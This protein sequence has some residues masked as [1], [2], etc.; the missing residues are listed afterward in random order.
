MARPSPQ[1][2]S[3]S[4]LRPAGAA[5]APPDEAQ[6]LEQWVQLLAGRGRQ[7]G[8]DAR[9]DCRAPGKREAKMPEAWSRVTQASGRQKSGFPQHNPSLP[10]Q[11]RG[12]L[13]RQLHPLILWHASKHLLIPGP[14]LGSDNTVIPHGAPFHLEQEPANTALEAHLLTQLTQKS[15]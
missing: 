8:L 3:S 10:H 7:L 5:A 15:L 6:P 4:A 13:P 11:S 2:S 14:E 9:Q 1:M 12:C